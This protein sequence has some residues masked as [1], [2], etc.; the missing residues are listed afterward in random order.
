MS[1]ALGTIEHMNE[2]L[3]TLIDLRSRVVEIVDEGAR[4]GLLHGAGDDALM[5]AIA[6]TADVTRLLEAMLIE[7]V[8]ELAERSKSFSRDERLTTRM[9]C[10]NV[11]ELT[12]RLTRCSPQT[13]GRLAVAHKAVALDWDPITGE[14]MP[15]RLPAMREAMLDG[16]TGTDGVVAVAGPLL[17]M[18]DRVD[19][20]AVLLADSV[21]AAEARGE[22]PDAAPPA[23]AD[24]LRVQA[25]VWAA[26]LDPDGAEPHDNDSAFR[27]GVTLGVARNGIIPIRGGLMPEVA[28]QFQRICDAVNSP[29]G[30][31]GSGVRFTVVETDGAGT[32]DPQ[33]EA[34]DNRVLDPRTRA[35]KQ[36]DA[37]ATALFAAAA[38]ADLPT[39]GG[40]APTLVITARAEDLARGDGW[41]F[42]EG[43]DEPVSIHAATHV[44][45]GGVLQRVIHDDD[46]KI[47]RLGT[48]ERVFNR[49]QRRAIALRDGG[50]IIPGCGVP[51]AWCELHH[52]HEASRG[53][54]THTDNGVLLCWSHHR[55]IDSGV[56]KIRMNNGV[57]EVRAPK[58]FD[59]TGRWRQVTKSRT[60][61]LS[62][63]GRRT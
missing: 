42:L 41:A 59:R 15:A 23:C 29:Y 34:D 8:G 18:R 12:Q 22:G 35:Q 9:G 28:A 27:R 56:W 11:N 19:R 39:I 63:I 43:C 10:H 2:L 46:G 40:A 36:H 17:A 13:A 57:P 54:P 7:G 25:Q 1:E 45:C 58:W 6:R 26:A 55:F 51:A 30:G 53:G 16:E 47:V 20:A 32:R 49:H 14:G 44:A 21:L 37:L 48:E 62:I 38:S 52:V 3:D 24:L 5:D 4:G 60:R 50:C 33:T 31:G 61:M